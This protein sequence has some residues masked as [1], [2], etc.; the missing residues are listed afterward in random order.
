MNVLLTI[1]IRI[2]TNATLNTDSK[3]KIGKSRAIKVTCVLN[4]N[5]TTIAAS[6]NFIFV[7]I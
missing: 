4:F 3:I 7:C 2:H 1:I 5:S 6:A